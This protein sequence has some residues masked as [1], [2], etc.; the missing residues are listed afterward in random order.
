[1]KQI[2]ESEIKRLVKLGDKSFIRVF[3]CL[4][5]RIS[6]T[7]RAT[8]NFRFQS[9]GKRMQMKIGVY[10]ERNSKT[11]MDVSNAIKTAIDLKNKSLNGDN[12]KLDLRR[13]KFYEIETV[14]DLATLY[15][16]NKK[17][18]IR[19]VHILERLYFKEVHPFIGH[20]LLKKYTLLT[21]MKS[22][23]KF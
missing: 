2:S 16:L 7:N 3:D 15:L 17:D 23:N 18:K 22:F 4:Y 9:R 11:L 21:Y 10:G 8:W 5:L 13:K 12:P 14:E 20:M 19:T 6:S 1:M